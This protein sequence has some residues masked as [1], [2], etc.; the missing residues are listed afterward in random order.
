MPLGGSEPCALF[1]A[2]LSA[3]AWLSRALV[4]VAGGVQLLLWPGFDV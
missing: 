1:C 3:L 2:G 4:F